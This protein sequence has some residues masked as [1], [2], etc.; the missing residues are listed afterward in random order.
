MMYILT[1]A[2]TLLNGMKVVI[3]FHIFYFSFHIERADGRDCTKVQWSNADYFK[4][5]DPKQSGELPGYC[6][7]GSLLFNNGESFCISNEPDEEETDSVV[8]CN[9][10]PDT[11]RLPQ[12]LMPIRYKVK[13]YAFI[14][15]KEKYTTGEVEIEFEC[16][17]STNQIVFHANKESIEIEKDSVKVTSSVDKADQGRFE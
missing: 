4:P 10:R 17:E 13:I 11:Y 16:K 1:Y 14:D 6:V 8:V 9:K 7:P 2:V 12:H 15:K 5:S 3:C